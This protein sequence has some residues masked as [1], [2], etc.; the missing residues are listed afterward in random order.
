MT[1]CFGL[2]KCGT[3]CVLRKSLKPRSNVLDFSQ[4]NMQHLSSGKCVDRLTTLI[5]HVEICHNML[6]FIEGSL[7]EIKNFAST[8]VVQQYIYFF[9]W[10]ARSLEQVL[11]QIV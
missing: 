1:K 11:G 3:L 6:Y 10:F 7:I 5:I 4:Y 9:P 8:N 2:Q